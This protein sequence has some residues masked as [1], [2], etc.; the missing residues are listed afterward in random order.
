MKT[1]KT[2]TYGR[3]ESLTC[4]YNANREC[5]D[6]VNRERCLA[7]CAAVLG[8]K[9]EKFFETERKAEDDLR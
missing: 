8:D 5:T 3:C 4:C 7:L 1:E 9:V 2:M 6:K